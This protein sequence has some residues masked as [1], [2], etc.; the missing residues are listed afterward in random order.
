MKQIIDNTFS[1]FN[2][3]LELNLLKINF[4]V[5]KSIFQN[6]NLFHKTNFLFRNKNKLSEA[7]IGVVSL[8]I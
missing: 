3:I 8:P 1:N 6:K 2:N 4:K 5:Y 7:I